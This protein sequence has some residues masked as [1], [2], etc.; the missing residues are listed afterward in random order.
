MIRGF[1]DPYSKLLRDSEHK[2]FNHLKFS[3]S[4]IVRAADVRQNL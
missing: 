1:Y 3:L 2:K 4:L